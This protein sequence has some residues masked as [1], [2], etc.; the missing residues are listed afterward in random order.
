MAVITATGG[1]MRHVEE[2]FGTG[3]AMLVDRDSIVQP[4]EASVFETHL[5]YILNNPSMAK[6]MAYHNFK[7]TTI[8]KLSPERSRR[9]VLKVYEHALEK[10]AATP[11]TL[12]QTPYRGRALLRLS[13][14]QL[15]QAEIDYRRQVNATEVR[16]L[17]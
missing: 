7:L 4:E 10:P 11:L 3:G 12:R 9:I 13:S 6:K 16:F 8:G 15:G 14:R 2:L 17:L 5:R 1:A